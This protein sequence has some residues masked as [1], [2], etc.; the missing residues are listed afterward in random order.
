VG[1]AGAD[2]LTGG[3]GND[4]FRYNLASDS[5]SA[6]RDQIQDFTLGDIIDLS[7]I[8]ANSGTN[9]DQ[10][11]SF[12]GTAAFGSHAGELRYENVSGSTWAVQGDTN[13]DGVAD[14]EVLVVIADGHGFTSGDFL[15]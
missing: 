1:W 12:I 13:G 9:G 15:L 10:A 6:S 14:F 4:V 7:R 5:T 11:F 8:D 2:T 3:L